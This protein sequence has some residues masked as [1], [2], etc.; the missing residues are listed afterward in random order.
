MADIFKALHRTPEEIQAYTEKHSGDKD[1]I[2]VFDVDH[3]SKAAAYSLA[4]QLMNRHYHAHMLSCSDYPGVF[5][6][7]DLSNLSPVELE[8]VKELCRKSMQSDAK[9]ETHS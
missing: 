4:G 9:S 8:E 5:G 6:V 1:I 2:I 7:Y 3:I